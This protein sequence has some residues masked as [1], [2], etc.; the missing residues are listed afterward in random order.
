MSKCPLCETELEKIND[1]TLFCPKDEITLK[2][3]KGRLTAT[4]D[5]PKKKGLIQEL[6]EKIAEQE[7]T[8]NQIKDALFGNK[9][10]D[11]FGI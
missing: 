5:D 4:A 11:L 9:D 6:Q 2:L 10:T 3:S 8:I 1:E 7:L